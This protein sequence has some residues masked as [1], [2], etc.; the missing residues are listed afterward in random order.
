M[1]SLWPSLPVLRQLYLDEQAIAAGAKNS[2]LYTDEAIVQREMLRA[3]PRVIS[4]LEYFWESIPKAEAT[5][6]S[7]EEVRRAR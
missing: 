1:L 3:H 6:I 4:A 5:H 2:A 7:K